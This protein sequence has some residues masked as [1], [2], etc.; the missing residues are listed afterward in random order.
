MGDKHEF[1]LL[2]LWLGGL[3]FYVIITAQSPI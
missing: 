1:D 3:K 2:A